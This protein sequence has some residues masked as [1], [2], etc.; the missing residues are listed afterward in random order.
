MRTRQWLAGLAML[1]ATG[2]ACAGG[3]PLGIDHRLHYDNRGIWARRNQQAL[4]YG[5]IVAAGAG[6]VALGDQDEFGDTLWRS[7]D[8]MLVTGVGTTALK[9]GFRRER[10]SQTDDP[11]TVSSRATAKASPAAKSPR[12]PR[13]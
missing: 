12:W 5:A 10:P 2:S 1:A 11:P 7:V 3:G 8:A 13:R 9:Y 4:L 6:A